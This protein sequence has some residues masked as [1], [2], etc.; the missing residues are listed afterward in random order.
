MRSQPGHGVCF[1]QET[2]DDVWGSYIFEEHLDSHLTVRQA[3]LVQKYVSESTASE[4]ADVSEASDNRW[5][6]WQ[7]RSHGIPLFPSQSLPVEK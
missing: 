6:R 3:L 7:A 2:F 5:L 1:I 4:R